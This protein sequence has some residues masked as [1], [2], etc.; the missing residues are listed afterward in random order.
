M[1]KWHLYLVHIKMDDLGFLW[2][3]TMLDGEVQFKAVGYGRSDLRDSTQVV[4]RWQVGDMPTP[5]LPNPSFCQRPLVT[6][7]LEL[8]ATVTEASVT[9]VTEMVVVRYWIRTGA[10]R[11]KYSPESLLRVVKRYHWYIA[12]Q[13]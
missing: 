8:P 10:L 7:H 9:T 4:G 3:D 13:L 6:H 11:V 5:T 2:H 1:L 12:R